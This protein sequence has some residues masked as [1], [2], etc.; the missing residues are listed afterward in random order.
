MS[1]STTPAHSA[2]KKSH[3][4]EPWIIRTYAGFGDARQANRRFLENLSRGQRGLSIAFDLPTQNGYDPDAP[5]AAGEV[6]NQEDTSFCAQFPAT[7]EVRQ[8]SCPGQDNSG[9]GGS[10]FTGGNWYM[11]VNGQQF[12]SIPVAE[13]DGEIWRLATGAGSFSWDLQLVDDLTQN[14]KT[15]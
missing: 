1:A 14:P 8:G 9:S 11:T 13:A 4:R 3:P 7:G 6:L 15:V 2:K 12:P 5:V 10:N